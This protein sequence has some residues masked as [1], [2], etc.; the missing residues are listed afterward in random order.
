LDC[1]FTST[2]RARVVRTNGE[3]SERPTAM[4]PSA[5]A[6]CSAPCAVATPTSS[7]PSSGFAS[8]N[9]RIP[10]VILLT[11][12]IRMQL[13]SSSN[14]FTPSMS[15]RAVAGS[16][17]TWRRP[18]HTYASLPSRSFI[19]RSASLIIAPSKPTPAITPKYS[20]SSLPRSIRCRRPRSAMS[21]AASMSVGMPRLV[22]SRFPV[23]AGM[24]ATGIFEPP[25]SR[26]TT[27]SE[28]CTMP[29]PP[30]TTSRSTPAWM[31]LRTCLGALRLLGTSAQISS[32]TSASVIRRRSSSRPPPRVLRW[33]A[34]TAIFR[35]VRMAWTTTRSR[36]AVISSHF[37]AC[38]ARPRRC[39]SP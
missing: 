11:L 33:W 2:R 35:G 34:T 1:S 27:S 23:P 31:A 21:T 32:S 10:P 14:H 3:L 39:G 18:V 5:R 7:H 25:F 24:I 20:P 12:P 17:S 8:S 26:A 13:A 29:S 37:P 36:E 15:T 4:V 22:A 28:R 19:F 9:A 30:H 38:A 16:P 6:H